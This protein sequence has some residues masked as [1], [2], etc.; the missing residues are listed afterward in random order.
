MGVE[1][2]R[3]GSLSVGGRL[4]AGQGIYLSC[5]YACVRVCTCVCRCL[6][7]NASRDY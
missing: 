5:L 7:V 6:C 2:R 4:W 3:Q 1:E